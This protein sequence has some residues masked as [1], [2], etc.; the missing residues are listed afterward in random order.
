MALLLEEH[1]NA[2]AGRTYQPLGKGHTIWLQCG[3]DRGGR[4]AAMHYS[5]MASCQRNG[6]D[7]FTYLRDIFARLPVLQAAS[8]VPADTLRDVLP[9]R[10]ANRS[11]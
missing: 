3:S 11:E 4:A 2:H 9:D 6:I 8:T 7:P 1:Q 5:L 10:W